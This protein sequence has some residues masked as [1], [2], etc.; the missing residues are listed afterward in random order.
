M[1]AS[2]EEDFEGG[3]RDFHTVRTRLDEAP[4]STEPYWSEST[5]HKALF[6]QGE[7]VGFSKKLAE[8]QTFTFEFTPFDGSPEVA[9]FDLRGLDVHLHK[10]AEACGWAY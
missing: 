7:S 9:R 3:P 8:T 5:D 4:A 6:T 10:L 2:V 1:P